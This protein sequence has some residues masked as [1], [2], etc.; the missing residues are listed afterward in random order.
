MLLTGGRTSFRWSVRARITAV[1]MAIVLIIQLVVV[2]SLILALRESVEGELSARGNTA[3]TQVAAGLH[4][5]D[6]TRGRLPVQVP[7][8]YLLQVVDGSG[9]VVASSDALLDRPPIANLRPTPGAPPQSR[10]LAIPG[11]ADHA[12]LTALG[13]NTPQG[14]QTVYAATPTVEIGAAREPFLGGAIATIVVLTL[15]IGIII[16][17][18]VRRA[19]R[20]I[21]TMRAELAEITGGELERRVSVPRPHDEVSDL[22]EAVNV[23]LSRLENFLERQRAF[24]ADASHELRSPLTALHTQL[25]VALAHPEDEDWLEVARAALSDADRLQR[26][27]SDL[28]LLARIDARVGTEFEPLDLGELVS[29]EVSHRHRGVAVHT[30]VERGAVIMGNRMRL[31]RLLT[32]LLDNAERH[33]RSQVWVTV[34]VEDGEAVMEV[35]DDGSG[36]PEKDRERVFQ[37]FQRLAESRQRDTGG[38]GLG[39]PIAAEIA[40][41][42]DGRLYAAA[43]EAE[44]GP[45]KA[46]EG[47]VGAR[48]I[49]RIP[50]HGRSR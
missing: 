15:L 19:L 41:S 37:R 46:A 21:Q 7:G 3:T 31:A 2:A 43:P 40:A 47:N 50:L 23:T 38:T 45:P 1:A 14:P 6:I 26:I 8:Y 5:G 24:V 34:T 9:R 36:I 13:V 48:L 44:G 22:A 30:K 4:S 17:L 20:P 29:T 33:A 11:V 18:S 25:E 27:V 28:L 42:H 16:W 10:T 12:H 35:V 39:L 49:L 32:N